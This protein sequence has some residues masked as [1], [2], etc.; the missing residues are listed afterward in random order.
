MAPIDDALAALAS[1][2]QPNYTQTALQFAV[3]RTTL[4]R[5][6]RG[7]TG[8]KSEGREKVSLLSYSQ[9]KTLVNYINMLTARGLPPT[10]AIVNNF[11]E[12]ICGQKPGKNWCA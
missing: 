7:L 11:A 8:S 1:Q 5:R 4:S 12:E 6:H 2:E 10:N 9:Q 3:D